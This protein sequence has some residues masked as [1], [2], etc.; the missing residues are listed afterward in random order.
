MLKLIDKQKYIFLQ[1][2]LAT[3][4]SFSSIWTISSSLPVFIQIV[5]DIV[6]FN[7]APSRTNH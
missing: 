2:F 1:A 7:W 6:L 4:I 5:C 3:S